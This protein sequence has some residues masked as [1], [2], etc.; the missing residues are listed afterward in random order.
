MQ[1]KHF[2]FFGERCYIPLRILCIN[3]LQYPQHLSHVGT[4][5]NGK[6]GYC[7]IA[8]YLIVGRIET[9]GSP[10][11]DV[12]YIRYIYGRAGACYVPG[13]RLRVDLYFEDIVDQLLPG[14]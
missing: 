14:G 9:V 4:D 11:R 10:F 5:G 8:R 12:V 3:H 1:Y 6:V 7:S 2:V 13:D